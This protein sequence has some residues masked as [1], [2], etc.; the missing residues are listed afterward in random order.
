M[1]TTY[2]ANIGQQLRQNQDAGINHVIIEKRDTSNVDKSN[3]NGCHSYTSESWSD[4]LNSI[5]RWAK[6]DAYYPE[7]ITFEVVETLLLA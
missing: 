5:K 1:A 6:E 3:T 2:H 4:D 7:L